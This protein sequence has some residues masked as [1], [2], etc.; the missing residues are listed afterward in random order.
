MRAAVATKVADEVEVA[1]L[2]RRAAPRPGAPRWRMS[3]SRLWPAGEMVPGPPHQAV[4]RRR[5]HHPQQ[6]RTRLHLPPPPAPPRRLDRPH[7]TRRTTRAHPTGLGRP[8]TTTTP[9]PL[10]AATV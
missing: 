8:H 6:R 9:K 10:L 3:V 2:H 5:P 1:A 7:H 4:G